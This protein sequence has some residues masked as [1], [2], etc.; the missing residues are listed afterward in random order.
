MSQHFRNCKSINFREFSINIAITTIS[1][2]T[3]CN[4]LYGARNLYLKKKK[5][6]VQYYI[7]LILTSYKNLGKKMKK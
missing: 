1:Q 7:K 3:L 5:N 6:Y 2:T 4:L